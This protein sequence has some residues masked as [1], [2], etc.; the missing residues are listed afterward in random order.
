[1]HARRWLR[2][3]SH[4]VSNE[5]KDIVMK[6]MRKCHYAQNVNDFNNHYNNLISILNEK[7]AANIIAYLNTNW[8]HT[9]PFAK[10][11]SQAYVQRLSDPITSFTNN[12]IESWHKLLKDKALGN[13]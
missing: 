1:M 5:I 6:Y 7:D 3:S 4:H 12:F 10:L 9:S 2:D 11:W 13:I 8:F